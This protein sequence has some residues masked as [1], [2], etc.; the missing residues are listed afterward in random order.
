MP[1]QGV[2]AM[3]VAVI[4]LV[5]SI[6]WI[7]LPLLLLSELRQIRKYLSSIETAVHIANKRAQQPHS[8][9]REEETI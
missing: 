4:L 6:L 2:L 7:L 1:A 9:E 5:L 3:V 8:A